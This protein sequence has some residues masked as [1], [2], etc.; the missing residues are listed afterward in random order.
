MRTTFQAT[1]CVFAMIGMLGATPAYANKPDWAGDKKEQHKG[2]SARGQNDDHGRDDRR[3]HRGKDNDRDDRR[4]H[5]D[6]RINGYFNDH[7]REYARTYYGEQFRGGHCPPGLAKKHNGCMP[8]GQAKKWRRG[9]VLP[10]DV[11]F[12]DVPN[13]LIV[14][15]GYP[16]A[17]HRYVRV[18]ADILLI[19]VGTGMVVDAIEDLS[20]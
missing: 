2:K 19:A 13:S 9:Y 4:G 12:Y 16:P 10:R 6:I 18:A 20:R 1:I 5:V 17:G 8:P 7:Q 14:E 3:G 11:V 15:L